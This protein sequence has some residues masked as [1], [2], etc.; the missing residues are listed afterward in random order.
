MIDEDTDYDDWISNSNTWLALAEKCALHEMYPLAT[1]FYSMGLLKDTDAFKK[2]SIW[3]RFAK[4]CYRCNRISDAQLAV[5]VRSILN[6]STGSIYLMISQNFSK[7]YRVLLQ[8]CNC[9]GRKGA[10]RINHC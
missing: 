6:Y 1:D 7:H 5:Q 3:F 9:F 10:G 2:S 4:S 8:T